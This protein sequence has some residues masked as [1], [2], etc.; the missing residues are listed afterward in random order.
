MPLSNCHAAGTLAV[1]SERRRIGWSNVTVGGRTSGLEVFH[2]RGVGPYLVTFVNVNG[3]RAEMRLA[4]QHGRTVVAALQIVPNRELPPGGLTSRALR[5]V[6]VHAHLEAFA[7]KLRSPYGRQEVEGLLV[8]SELEA[9][10][11]APELPEPR[12]TSGRRRGRRPISDEV[13]L[14]VAR[15]YAGAQAGSRPVQDAA[16]VLRMAPARV[17]DLVHRARRRGLLTDTAQGLGGGELT[18]AAKAM[19]RTNRAGKDVPANVR[20]TNRRQPK[21]SQRQ[22]TK[23]RKTLG[24]LR[25]IERQ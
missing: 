18:A 21:T 22:R 9:F 24:K 2:E 7:S 16:A 23:K 8:G 25:L 4:L 17:R 12:D 1:V 15:A 10:L 5:D 19:L 3:W 13:L 20:A 11:T 6:P 14:E